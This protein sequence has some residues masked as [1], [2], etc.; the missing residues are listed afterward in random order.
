MV[1]KNKDIRSMEEFDKR[2][3]PKRTEYIEERERRRPEER[4]RAL[5]ESFIKGMAER[6]RAANP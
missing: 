5:A 2:Y 3:F 6:L 4:G 1:E